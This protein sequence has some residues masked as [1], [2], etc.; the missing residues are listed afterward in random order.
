MNKK[1]VVIS[2]LFFTQSMFC[3]FNEQPTK[4][5]KTKTKTTRKISQTT[6][7]EAS[8]LR[9]FLVGG[10]K[11]A[12][13]VT[14]GYVIYTAYKNDY[15]VDATQAAVLKDCNTTKQALSK[16]FDQ[17]RIKNM[18]Q[19]GKNIS[20]ISKSLQNLANNIKP[21]TDAEVAEVIAN[22]KDESISQGGGDNDRRD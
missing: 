21:K 6:P 17:L 8:T 14:L 15:N 22:K 12:A 5:I 20:E 3:A 11:T 19:V 16:E 4:K 10:S 1:Y 7:K 13:V 9:R 18:E 2:L